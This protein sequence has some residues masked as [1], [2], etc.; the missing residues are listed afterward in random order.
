[1]LEG[2]GAG[3][4]EV[5]VPA[6]LDGL[7]GLVLPGGES[8]TMTLGIEREG[9]AEP[10]RAFHAAGRPIFGTCA[11]LIMLDR[12][13]PGDHGHRRRAQR[14]RP[15]G[16][17]ASR[18]TSISGSTAVRCAPS[19]SARRGSREHGPGVEIL[20]AVDG[21]PVAAREGTALVDQLPSGARRGSAAPRAVPRARARRRARLTRAMPVRLVPWGPDDLPLLEALLGDPAMMA[22]LGGPE[23]LEEIA[24]RHRRYLAD[25]ERD[26]MFK[27]VDGAGAGVGWVGW[28]ERD[29]RDEPIL[30]IGWSVLAEYQGRGVATAA[31]SPG[32]R[33]RPAGAPR[34]ARSTPSR[35]PTTCPRTRSAAGSASGCWGRSRWSTRLRTRCG[36]TTGAWSSTLDDEA[37]AHRVLGDDL[38]LDELQQVV[39]GRRPSCRCRTGGCRRTAG[40]R[41][42]RR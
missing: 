34:G 2:L 38:R 30:E 13:P 10:L 5:R 8:T 9:L 14:V 16:A 40:A 12:E 4:R 41:P 25:R 37:V 17:L 33:S 6:D 3:V 32:D 23:R 21:H 22:H 7:D 18:R 11:G 24:E 19:S 26:P 42:S 15:S 29:W 28:W 1:M 35:R 27:I 20:A 36:A 31:T 39:R